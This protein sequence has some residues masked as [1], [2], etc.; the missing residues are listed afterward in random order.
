MKQ[1]KPALALTV[2]IALS[3]FLTAK[4]AATPRV[5]VFS[6]TKGFRHASIGPGKLLMLK[7]GRENGFIVDTTENSALITEENLKQ[8]AAVVFLNTT[9]DVLDARQQADF[10]RYIQAGGGFVGIHAAADC[11]YTWPWYGKLV[12]GYFKSH[13]ATQPAKVNVVDKSHPSTRHLP[14]VWE[15]T[16]EWYNFQVPP[17]DSEV[18]ILAKLDETSYKGGENGDHHPIVWYRAYDGGRA[19]YSGFGHTDETFS[20]PAYLKHILGGIQYAVGN[21]DPLDY[22]KARSVRV[23]EEDRFSKNI[24][25]TG[26]DEPTEMAVLPGLDVLVVQRKGEIMFYNAAQ[27]KLTQVAKLNVYSKAKVPGVNAEEGVLGLAADPNY[28][29]NKYVYVFYSP[30]DTSVNR[31][32]RFV[33]SNGK[34]DLASEKVI[35]Q[36]YSQRNICCHTGG[37]IAFGPDGSLFV[38]AGD[39]STPFDQSNSKYKLN[40]F[41]PLDDRPGFEQWD[42]RRSSGNTN[43]LRGKILRIKVK[44]DGSYSIPEGNLFPPGTDKARPEIYVMGNR[45]PYRISVDR[46]TGFL[47]WGEVGNDAANDSMARRGPRGYDELNQARKAGFFGWPLFVGNNYPYRRFDYATGQPGEAFDPA[48]P[49]NDSRNNTGLRELPPVSPAFIWYPYAAS[50]D[51]PDVGTGGRNAMAGPVY[52]PEF[53]PKETR[54]P[55]YYAG[56]LFFYDWIRGWIKPVTMKPNG[57]FD[58]MENFMAGTKLNSPIDME[59][60]PDGRIY[61]LEYGTGWFTK[62]PDAAL[63]RIEFNAGNRP[64]K[65]IIAVNKMTGSLPFTVQ[66][67]AEGSVDPDRDSVT[68]IWHYG[69]SVKQTKS[70]KTSFTLAAAGDYPVYVEVKDSKGA[71]GKSETKTVYAGNETPVVS[72]ELPENPG[73]VFPGQPIKYKV[74][75]KDKEDGTKVDPSRMFVKVD[76]ISGM[77]RA[78][79]VGHQ[80]VSAAMEGKAIVENSD[81]RTCHKVNEKSI[82]PSFTQVANKYA[83]DGK[84]TQYLSNKI[85]K[86]GSGVWGEVAM[87]AHPDLK[88]SET[89][90]IVAYILSLSKSSTVKSLPVQGSVTP[91]EKDLSGGKVMQLSASYTDKGGAKIKPLTGYNSVVIRS[92]QL[93]VQENKSVNNMT[94]AEFGGNKFAILGQGATGWLEFDPL[95]LSPVSAVE[96]MYAMQNPLDKGYTVELRADAPDGELL[97]TAEIPA[98][99]KAGFNTVKMPFQFAGDRARK[100][101]AVVR[102]KEGETQMAALST[103]KFIAK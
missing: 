86:G 59:L 36:F 40:G 32:S 63:A 99:G 89:Q 88:P 102:R 60:G 80:Q 54:L 8:Y 11:E 9:G 47:Y 94:V 14:D 78:Q 44:D 97:G 35:L 50:T 28:K 21:N 34:F 45:N 15:R 98:G 12:G 20:D 5:L 67:S 17:T 25:A 77:D 46:K 37:S 41:A 76:Y 101:Y 48:K 70:P 83:N 2:L 61:I 43:D 93:G 16:D 79:V 6:A 1:L 38:S 69:K 22:A 7:L 72:I 81:C 75:V 96:I 95:N 53:Y 68:Y 13:P 62:N 27:K 66:A 64:P 26:F 103:M 85:I 30:A 74:S 87:A 3:L 55:D 29:V 56:K 52:Y 73:F 49:I 84:A 65:A 82:G 100:L 31:L 71:I 39:N 51:F 18:K 57:D 10:E 92:P 24:L 90:K 58:H 4:K 33:F 19:F 23:P 91:A 42:A